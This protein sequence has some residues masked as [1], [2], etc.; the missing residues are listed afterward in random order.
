[1]LN[2]SQ[3]SLLQCPGG[4]SGSYTVPLSVT[5]IAENAFSYCGELTSV[6]LGTNVATI[7]IQSFFSCPKL[8][9]F[10]VPDKVTSIGSSTFAYCS[11]L[12]NITIGNSVGSIGNR[13]FASCI[14]LNEVNVDP[15]NPSFASVAGVLFNK[16]QKSLVYYPGGKAGNYAIP[17]GV[18]NIVNNAFE[19]SINLTG[20]EIPH[21]V[22]RIPDYAFAFCT[23]LTSITIPKS[24]TFLG[25]RAFVA[26]SSLTRV[27]FSGNAPWL[28]SSF[29]FYNA[30]KATVYYLPGT[31]GWG[32]TFGGRPAVLWNPT[33]QLSDNTF[34]LGPN[35]FGF[36]IKGTPNIPLVVE[37]GATLA[38]APWTPLQTCTLTNGTI[39]FSDPEWTHHPSRFYRIR[40]P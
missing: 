25:D 13:A 2:K 17:D 1:L 29:V 16:S 6:T 40:W 14:K 36:T 39:Y 32:T 30:S 24:V 9:W 20:V 18:T 10:T 31:T 27:Y 26:C 35:G 5:N 19:S 11:G 7:G 23:N 4:K 21:S 8:T 37:A 15:L 33:P 22:T 3:R 38:G 28:G 12:T 34:G